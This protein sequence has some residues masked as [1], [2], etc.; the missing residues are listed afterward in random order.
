MNVKGLSEDLSQQFGI[1]VKN[2]T[3]NGM[4]WAANI[5]EDQARQHTEDEDYTAADACSDVAER[6]R[7]AMEESA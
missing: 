2:A 4:N 6:I 1:S 7:K 5:V 3:Y